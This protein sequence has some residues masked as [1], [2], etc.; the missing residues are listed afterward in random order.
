MAEGKRPVPSRTRKLSP[1][2]PMVLHPTGCGRVGHRRTSFRQSPGRDIVSQGSD[3]FPDL[4]G[5][6]R[7]P[8]GRRGPPTSPGAAA[9]P[10]QF[11]GPAAPVAAAWSS[12]TGATV[13]EAMAGRL[14]RLAQLER[15]EV[16][17]RPRLATEDDVPL[18]AEWRRDFELEAIGYEREP[19][20][21]EANVR[22]VMAVGT[23]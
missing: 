22:R 11:S 9:T 8:A 14:Y 20:R 17:G 2:A 1:P 10:R 21:A 15:P 6:F 19:S 12:L 5:P 13:Q 4:S 18:L 3:A 16:P 23:G 7:F